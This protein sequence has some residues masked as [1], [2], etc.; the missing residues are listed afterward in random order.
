MATYS[1]KISIQNKF[2][3]DQFNMWFDETTD[4]QPS[5]KRQYASTI[6][7]FLIYIEECSIL[8]INRNK[9]I[10]FRNSPSGLKNQSELQPSL[11]SARIKYLTH[12]LVYISKKFPNDIRWDFTLGD[13]LKFAP[14][15]DEII[16]TQ[17]KAEAL[18]FNDLIS[19]YKKFKVQIK[20][21]KEWLKAYIVFRLMFNYN[22]DKKDIAKINPNSYDINTG[23]YK[24][25]KSKE[26]IQ[27]D[28]E[29]RSFFLDEGIDFLSYSA[30]TIYLKL[31]VLGLF[32]GKK[33]T[34]EVIRE[35]KKKFQIQCPR[36]GS[37]FVNDTQ[38]FGIAK[39]DILNLNGI[40]VCKTCLEKL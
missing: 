24:Q 1:T 10:S 37:F 40:L 28:Q 9:I 12:F 29:L 3:N 5:T 26:N 16:H 36:C 14:T 4:I 18:T 11:Q 25:S 30:D 7:R 33:I 20:I 13:L 17:N 38:Y 19:L 15:Q 21:N 23:I 35:T 39:M 32:L 8:E 2:N 27:F 22:L 34:Q 31:D 6:S